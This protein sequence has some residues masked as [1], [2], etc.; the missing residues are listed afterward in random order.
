MALV[1][2]ATLGGTILSSVFLAQAAAFALNVVIGTVLGIA[3][4][5]IF[6]KLAGKPENPNAIDLGLRETLQFGGDVPR[7]FIV[8]RTATAGS[9]VYGNTWGTVGDTPN[10]YMTQVIALS[11]LPGCELLKVFANSEPLTLD[12][13]S[14]DEKGY[15]AEEYNILDKD[16][17]W[18]KFYDGSQITADSFLVNKVSSADRPYLSSRVGKGVCYVIVTM[19]YNRSVFQSV[20]RYLFEMRGIPLYNPSRDSTVAGGSGT[21]RL[22]SPATWSAYPEDRDLSALPIYSL[23][24]GIQYEGD[25]FYGFQNMVAGQNPAQEAAAAINKCRTEN[26]RCGLE[27]PISAEIGEVLEQLLATCSGRISDSAGVRYVVRVGI[28]NSAVF[29][30]TDDTILINHE[31]MFTPFFGLSDSVNAALLSYSSPEQ[32]WKTVSTPPRYNG[33]Y[34]QR[35]GGRRLMVKI[36]TPAIYS[37][38]QA[39]KILKQAIAEA[40]RARRHTITVDQTLWAIEPGDEISWTSERN[41]Y[42]NKLFRVDG[43][44]DRAD[45]DIVL[46]IT[47]INPNDYDYDELTEF[48]PI[49][50][51]FLKPARA[52]I[53]ST[54]I[55]VSASSISDGFSGRRPAILLSWLSPSDVT[56]LEYQVRV[57]SNSA[58]VGEGL[59]SSLTPSVEGSTPISAGILSVT[60]YEVRARWIPGSARITSWS[61]WLSVTTGDFRV[62]FDDLSDAIIQQ[63]DEAEATALAA[64]ADAADALAAAAANGATVTQLQTDVTSLS[65]TFAE[66]ETTNALR[67]S[68]FTLGTDYWHF[69]GGSLSEYSWGRRSITSALSGPTDVDRPLFITRNANAVDQG[70]FILNTIKRVSTSTLD[71]GVPVFAGRRIEASANVGAINCAVSLQIY[72]RDASNNIVSAVSSSNATTS[73]NNAPHLND[74]LWVAADVPTGAVIAYIAMFMKGSTNPTALA[75]ATLFRPQLCESPAG[76]TEPRPYAPGSSSTAEAIDAYYRQSVGVLA[77]DG[78]AVAQSVTTLES[79]LGSLDAVVTDIATTYITETEAV[80]TINNEVSVGSSG[81][82]ATARTLAS[83]SRNHQNRLTAYYGIAVDGGGN[84]AFVRMIDGGGIPSAIQFG[85]DRILLDGDVMVNGTITTTKLGLLSATNTVGFESSGFTSTNAAAG[86][87]I[88]SLSTTSLGGLLFLYFNAILSENNP[89]R[90]EFRNGATVLKD[91]SYSPPA[92][93]NGQSGGQLI[94]MGWIGTL[95][96]G[97]KSLSVQLVPT[98]GSVVTARERTFICTE[99]RTQR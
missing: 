93:V 18:I 97:L 5:K 57:A 70:A 14:T 31:E 44:S 50:E 6:A 8:G 51:G 56:G 82:F 49:A 79:E 11:D 81:T 85:A 2:A 7:S 69:T 67:N 94:G 75:V 77:A 91:L 12:T 26:Y 39:Q 71:W 74:R 24:R 48:Q 10:A 64:Q 86:I 73:N 68:D 13:N 17:L 87:A 29:S 34:E 52:P 36:D 66:G 38:T 33:T 42:Q 3:T 65:A 88:A 61:G 47:E 92:Y 59:V 63:L 16:H 55:S 45:L 37:G 54:F 27:I 25:W 15:P 84:G 30:I 32:A 53:Q 72:F 28:S 1:T 60:T 98:S 9:L 83:A 99:F 21:H 41:G 23:M 19:L 90:L 22:G 20:P 58:L 78:L 43:V 35:D 4:N 62:T 95:T 76:A 96:S 46:D 40:Q 80:A 89:L